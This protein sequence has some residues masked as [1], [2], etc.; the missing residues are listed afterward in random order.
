MHFME[1]FNVGDE[2]IDF[3]FH[4]NVLEIKGSNE[5]VDVQTDVLFCLVY[6]KFIFLVCEYGHD[7]SQQVKYIFMNF[8]DNFEFIFSKGFQ[9]SVDRVLVD[10]DRII[11]F[12]VFDILSDVFNNNAMKF[13]I[14]AVHSV[15]DG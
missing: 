13:E 7:E 1:K 2:H 10:F 14:L 8:Q 6:G 4:D 3:L 9:I 11:D 5:V 15:I 12:L